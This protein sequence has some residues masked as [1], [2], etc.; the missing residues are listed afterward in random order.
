MAFS[1]NQQIIKQH[2]IKMYESFPAPCEMKNKYREVIADINC[3]ELPVSD[4]VKFAYNINSDQGMFE[5]TR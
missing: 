5:G 4:E 3:G 1:T 2:C